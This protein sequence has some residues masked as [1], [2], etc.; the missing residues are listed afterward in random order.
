MKLLEITD[1]QRG[2]T[3]DGPG[4][5]TTIFLKGCPLHCRWCHNPETQRTCR[6]IFYHPEK[7][8]GCFSCV[9]TCPNNAHSITN[10][11]HTFSPEKCTG[12]FSCTS[13]CPAGALEAAS[14]SISV[15]D[16]VHQVLLDRAFYRRRGGLTVS[17]GEPTLQK[18]GLMELLQQVKAEGISTCLE[19]CGV[20]SPKMIPD[21]L[22]C[23]DLFLYDLK[24]TDPARLLE[25]TGANL[26]QVLNNLMA[27]DNGGGHT[28][29]RCI[30]IPEVNL[31]EEHAAAVSNIFSALKNRKYVE[32]LPYHPY[33]LSKAEQLGRDGKRYRQPET[34]EIEQ[35]SDWLIH[36]NV[37]VKLYGTLREL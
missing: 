19:T 29:L 16:A 36:H 26:D 5:R 1:I 15:E 11:L 6:E 25:N 28:V 22:N 8:I 23:V 7:C 35:F 24:D 13:V 27:I 9:S 10:N 3:H 21:L 4:I 18:E 20:F 32:L 31:N 33:G 2:C 30:L 37:P 17:G 12:C 14:R 34:E